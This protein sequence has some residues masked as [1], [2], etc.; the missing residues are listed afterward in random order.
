MHK[1][2]IVTIACSTIGLFCATG[3]ALAETVGRYECSVIGLASQD[4]IGDTDGHRLASSQYACFGVE[5]LLKGALYTSS[6][7]TEWDGPHGTFVAG[8]G[9][10][11]AP[12]GLAVTQLTEGVASV[13][14]KDGKPAGTEASGK[15]VFK[16][17]SGAFAQLSGKVVKWEAKPAGFNRFSLEVTTDEEVTAA[18]KE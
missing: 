4:P 13:A 2:I 14:V 3:F 7:T 17:A 1:R 12:G 11:R 10:V 5:G 16:F 18:R 6:S 8:G 9:I 15:A